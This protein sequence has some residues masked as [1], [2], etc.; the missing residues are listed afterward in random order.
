L[1]PPCGVDYNLVFKVE[2]LDSD[3]NYFLNLRN[4]SGPF[5]CVAA[6]PNGILK[7]DESNLKRKM[8][9]I[10]DKIPIQTRKIIWNF[11]KAGAS[12]QYM[13]NYFL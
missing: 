4:L 7:S 8:K 9:N 6:A 11:Y 1:C 5:E 13:P 3:M 2:T 10:F 12:I